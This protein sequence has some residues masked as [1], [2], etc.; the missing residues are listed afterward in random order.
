MKSDSE[1]IKAIKEIV[2]AYDM[3]ID[4]LVNHK[5]LGEDMKKIIR[6]IEDY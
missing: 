5:T 3:K 2:W 6:I 1:K 4:S